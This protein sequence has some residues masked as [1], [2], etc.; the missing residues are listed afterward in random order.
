[1]LWIAR[2]T[3]GR[4]NTVLRICIV[5]VILHCDLLVN[6][7][8]WVL[9]TCRYCRVDN[10]DWNSIGT[11]WCSFELMFPVYLVISCRRA[12]KWKNSR[13]SWIHNITEIKNTGKMMLLLFRSI[14]PLR[15]QNLS[16]ALTCQRLI[17]KYYA[18]CSTTKNM[19]KDYER[20]FFIYFLFQYPLKCIIIDIRQN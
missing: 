9:T 20:L 11:Y 7:R 14:F 19:L 8:L 12:V 16:T 4:W 5:N 15:L 1:M 3:F 18:V 10:W 2:L 13:C 17:S 6:V